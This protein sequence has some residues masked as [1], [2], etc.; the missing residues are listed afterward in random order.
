MDRPV[1]LWDVL[2]HLNLK[3]KH[4]DSQMLFPFHPEPLYAPMFH[5]AFGGGHKRWI[6]LK[7][8]RMFMSS[9]IFLLSLLYAKVRPGAI[10]FYA[11]WNR[12]MGVQ[13]WDDWVKSVIMNNSGLNPGDPVIF[14]DGE[15]FKDSVIFNKGEANQSIVSNAQSV[16]SL[17]GN[18]LHISD[19]AKMAD[20]TPALAKEMLTG[21]MESM[22]RGI[23]LVESTA[24]S[25]VGHFAQM[26]YEAIDRRKRG[27]PTIG[28]DFKCAFFPWYIKKLNNL[29][30]SEIPE[31]TRRMEE[32]NE[33]M[34]YFH[35]Q[36]HQF[37]QIAK[38]QWA[39]YHSKFNG[40]AFRRSWSELWQEHP[41]TEDEAFYGD[42]NAMFLAETMRTLTENNMI[43][44]YPP[45]NSETYVSFDFGSGDSVYTAMVFWQVVSDQHGGGDG[46]RLRVV[47]FYK[48]QQMDL[49]HYSAMMNSKGYNIVKLIL[50]HDAEHKNS[51][52]AE[53]LTGAKNTSIGEKLN[54][55]GWR[56]IKYIPKTNNKMSE[57]DTTK[58]ILHR[59]FFNNNAHAISCSKGLL[60]MLR[61]IKR[62]IDSNL[63]VM[64]E[65][66][67]DNVGSRDSYDALECGA[68]Y[69]HEFHH[70][71][72]ASPAMSD[73][74][75]QRFAEIGNNAL[76]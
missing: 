38:E 17:S 56:N 19:Y 11:N 10:N 52:N 35:R 30:P 26:A 42:R 55:F 44:N 68:R 23:I 62:K 4:I 8:R 69:F 18:L 39:W 14:R 16:R 67:R 25:P 34:E 24:A 72:S 21:S 48:A 31:A 37:P 53:N 64:P 13:F 43:G 15:A 1:D 66:V 54:A 5:E 41:T 28:E 57:V 51:K 58:T 22:P 74:L 33:F 20:D 29:P 59:T 47:D 40:A 9:H 36:S 73:Y 27:I 32:D 7:S 65:I 12:R 76:H 45:D 71:A 50:P 46:M 49:Q 70:S 6:V 75:A 3:V 61:G 2:A 63:N 60:D